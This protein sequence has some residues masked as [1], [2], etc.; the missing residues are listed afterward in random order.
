MHHPTPV[1]GGDE[2]PARDV[3]QRMSLRT[4]LAI[5]VT[6]MFAAGAAA[7]VPFQHG[8]VIVSGYSIAAD[9]RYAD[10]LMA[11]YD[12]RGQFQRYLLPRTPLGIGDPQFDAHGRLFVP[13]SGRLAILSPDGWVQSEVYGNTFGFEHFTLNQAGTAFGLLHGSGP[14]ITELHSDGTLRSFDAA[15][16]FAMGVDLA[17]DQCTLFVSGY[18]YVDHQPV[19]EIAVLDVCDPARPVTRVFTLPVFDPGPVRILPDGDLV[20][21]TDRGLSDQRLVIVSSTGV[22]RRVFP[23]RATA[24]AIDPGGTSAWI[25]GEEGISKIAL[26]TGATLI[27]PLPSPFDYRIEGVAVRGEARAAIPPAEV[28][29]LDPRCLAA[30][31]LV[32]LAAGVFAHRA[33]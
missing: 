22:V 8:D 10:A 4:E 19:G 31:T 14:T 2:W 17:A 29:A 6:T 12:A 15:D 1:Y 18:K 16:L 20:V 28:P 33:A 30:L 24:I 3:V 27:G 21:G 23:I 7:Q 5:L 11:V 25:V 13:I 9:P 26:D 32:L